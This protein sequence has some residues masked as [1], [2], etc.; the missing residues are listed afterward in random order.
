[1]ICF[2]N[3][4]I[5]LGLN[6]VSRREDGY[7]NLET[8]FYPIGVS[9]ALEIVVKENLQ[10]DIFV[11][12]G[13]K[14]DAEPDNN[15]VVK[16]LHLMRAHYTFP[17]IEIHLLKKIPFGAGIG[18]G[19]ADASFMLKLL[20]TT[21][22]L[23]AT[24]QQLADWARELGADCPFFIYNRPL[25]ASGIGEVFEEVHLDLSQYTIA[26]VK[27]DIHIST[28]DAFA[29]ITPKHPHISLTEII[30]MPLAEWKDIMVNDFEEGLISKFPQIGEIKHTLYQQGAVYA[31]LTGSGS[32]IYGIFDKKP[33]GLEKIFSDCYVWQ[34]L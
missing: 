13:I 22:H 24:D 15:L 34:D 33:K 27:P 3:A 4:K 9:D 11:E 31:S 19:S 6:I 8:V 20:N 23:G 30:K 32:S 18:G 5:N 29:G 26:L 21:F 12:A 7:H 14:I 10:Q 25:F 2:P 17:Y 16:A 28:K 1:M